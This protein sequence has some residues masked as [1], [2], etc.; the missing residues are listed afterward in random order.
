MLI[1]CGL[2]AKIAN[3][4]LKTNKK[5]NLP[6]LVTGASG[7]RIKCNFFLNQLIKKFQL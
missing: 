2:T 4:I 7:K 6:I 3:R 1:D 5:S